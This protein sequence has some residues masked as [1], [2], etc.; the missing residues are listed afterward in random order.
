MASSRS[1]G[2]CFPATDV[3]ASKPQ[4]RDRPTTT[5]RSASGWPWSCGGAGRHCDWRITTCIP[6]VKWS[7]KKQPRALGDAP[8]S[9][10]AAVQPAGLHTS[11]KPAALPAAHAALHE[12]DL[13]RLLGAFI[14]TYLDRVAFGRLRFAGPDAV[15]AHARLGADD[16]LLLGR[17]LRLL[18]ALFRRSGGN[19]DGN[20]LAVLGDRRQLPGMESPAILDSSGKGRDAGDILRS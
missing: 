11:D 19:L 15:V 6:A 17:R 9:V 12:R 13:K 14:R 16:E 8:G 10:P 4:R 20:R 2:L 5:R 7:T 3:S 1:A 18:A